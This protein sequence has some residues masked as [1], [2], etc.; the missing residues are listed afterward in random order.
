MYHDAKFH[1]RLFEF[2]SRIKTF[3]NYYTPE[4]FIVIDINL[5]KQQYVHIS[6]MRPRLSRRNWLDRRTT[7]SSVRFSC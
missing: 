3:Y 6:S 4:T 7:S 5:I 1:Y 2:V